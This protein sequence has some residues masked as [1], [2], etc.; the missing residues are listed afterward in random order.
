MD[1]KNNKEIKKTIRRSGI[2]INNVQINL[3]HCKAATYNLDQLIIQRD[4]DIAYLQ[5]PY[6]YKN[7]L[8]GI[9]K[10]HRIYTSGNGVKR[11]AIV[12]SNQKIDALQIS[13]LSDDDMVVIEFSY[14]KLKFIAASIYLDIDNDMNRDLHKLEDIVKLAQGKGLI[15][16]MDSNARSK[17]WH[18]KLTNKRGK[19]LEEFVVANNL[20]LM[21]N[22]TEI[23][24]FESSTGSSN[25]DLTIVNQNMLT[26]MRNWICSDEES[27][28]DHRLITYNLK[29]NCNNTMYN[30]YGTRY[31]VKAERYNDFKDMLIEEIKYQFDIQKKDYDMK[32]REETDL[33]DTLEAIVVTEMN[34]EQV[35]DK[36]ENAVN[37]ACKRTFKT[38]HAKSKP[39]EQKSVPWWS[40]ELTILRKKVCAL[41]RKYQRTKND[42]NL[43]KNRKDNYLEWKRKYETTIRK[44]KLESWK[45]YCTVTESSN[46]WN[47]A[48]K[49]AFGKLKPNITMTT[50]R[51][52]DGSYTTDLE[53]TMELLME[54]FAPTDD[55]RD[56]S[57]H[58]TETRKEAE[59]PLNTPNDRPFTKEEI[60]MIINSM[61]TNKAPGENGITVEIFSLVFKLLPKFL[62]AVYNGCL[63]TG[64]FPRKWKHAKIIP[65]IK[66]GKE[67]YDDASKFR[68]ISLLNIA[69][70]VLEK[71]LINR[72]M[73]HVY[74]NNL[75]N[76]RQYG[77]TPQTS[78]VDAVM[79]LK[80]TV[81]DGLNKGYYIAIISLDVKGAFD[82]AWWP[83]I[84]TSLREF[85][86]P[87]NIYELSKSYFN[88]RTAS[89]TINSFSFQRTI[90]K[91]CPQGSCCGPGFWN[92]QYNSLL[93]LKYS[94]GTDVLAFADDFLV[95]VKGRSL[96][97]LEN[98]SNIDLYKVEKWAKNHKITFNEQ[99]SRLLVIS[100][101]KLQEAPKLNIILNNK[102]LLQSE[103]L[104]YLGII[105]DKKF[106]FQEHIEKVTQKCT[107]LIHALAKS[108][109]I[110]WGLKHD[111]MKII[112]KGAILPIISYGVPV[113][114]DAINKRNTMK[115]K[116]VQRLINIKMAKAFR[117]TS[118]EAL[119]VLTKTTPIILELQKLATFYDI[120]KGNNKQITMDI[121][122]HYSKWPHP[123]EICA[124]Q[125]KQENI[126]YKFEIFTDGSKRDAGVG[127]GIAIFIDK[128]LAHQMQY[129][130]HE[131]C[132]NN[133]AEQLA[134][135]KALTYL[136]TH[137]T[138][139][140]PQKTAVLHTD[141]KITLQS[142]RNH[143]NQHN[144][145]ALIRERTKK[146]EIQ[147]WTIH[148]A[149]I[150]AHSGHVGN[151][152]AD[153]LAK[154]AAD[155]RNLPVSYDHKPASVVLSEL[156]AVNI[157]KWETEWN[158]T[159]NG[160][161]TKSFIPSVKD[162]LKLNLPLTG[163]ITTFLTGHGQINSYFFRFK[164]KDSPLCTCGN[165]D[166]TVDHLLFRCVKLD[167]ERQLF[168]DDMINR[169]GQWTFD[170]VK[171]IKYYTKALISYFNSIDLNKL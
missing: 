41:R 70:K 32:T 129:R 61:D 55:A 159:V 153:N 82:A 46:P 133:Q 53:E 155:N 13:Q 51:K 80:K 9:S 166:Q 169:Y 149:W 57:V 91:G 124:V 10:R 64:C 86:C 30:F 39:S 48:Y 73:H 146:L 120:K 138:L 90:S 59:K 116:R 127:A 18:D 45:N 118:N 71:L 17:T 20:H 94:K 95:I 84:L 36:L 8:S 50:L 110:N 128:E 38:M 4:I 25:V 60:G 161:V 85:K 162:R 92:I 29:Q 81:Q 160:S 83:S 2:S 171:L 19:S 37:N 79:S 137:H 24:T 135:L 100:R 123:T 21:N 89:L 143:A 74:S 148:Y 98:Y 69:A 111:V 119:C 75:M 140:N 1:T 141:S 52:P 147:N 114:I 23:T 27:F 121:P 134:I 87:R 122:R 139:P 145:I 150:K 125:E 26:W 34:M 96:L 44:S 15:L 65:V 168:K 131:Y 104:K 93:N 108:A 68:P 154:Q 157:N 16:A 105:I 151:E 136:E 54:S 165:E 11:A 109:K 77:F 76:Q 163:N 12:V 88:E 67:S 113:W 112:Y 102:T 66:T 40:Q 33:D 115:F 22:N 106:N 62:T 167:R 130:L 7:K 43:R 35:V 56:D 164:I 126:D 152:T 31:I 14:G 97:E 49:L 117:T 144:L 47:A 156:E 170:K 63:M 158:D 99:K 5:E 132:S 42:E 28:S 103:S 58:H 107:N 142:L 3:K 72:I 6:L 101:K 78:T